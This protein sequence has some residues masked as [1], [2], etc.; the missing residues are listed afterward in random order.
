MLI[1]R[2]FIIRILNFLLGIRLHIYGN[3]PVVQGLIV[4][5]HRSTHNYA[6]PPADLSRRKKGSRIMAAHRIPLQDFRSNFVD[7][8][9]LKVDKTPPKKLKQL[10]L[11]DIQLSISQK[12][13]HIFYQ[14]QSSLI[15][16]RL[17]WPRR[18]KQL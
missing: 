14:P 1:F 4:A 8:K 7:E 13:R 2:D 3:A 11:K 15:S 17:Q 5:N 6:E 16:A 12:G 9:I 10:L 18:L